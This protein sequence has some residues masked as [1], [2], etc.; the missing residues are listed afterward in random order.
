MALLPESDFKRFKAVVVNGLSNPDA[1]NDNQFTFLHDYQHRFDL[2]GRGAFISEKQ[3]LY[4]EVIE[5]QL[6]R[7]LGESY[8]DIP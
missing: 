8:E 2:Y 5:D 3:R 7:K 1:L 4:F 6:Q